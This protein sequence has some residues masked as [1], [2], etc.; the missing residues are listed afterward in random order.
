MICTVRVNFG[1]VVVVA[2]IIVTYRYC[3]SGVCACVSLRVCVSV[4]P[5]KHWQN[6]QKLRML[7]GIIVKPAVTLFRRHF[8][9]TVDPGSY[10]RSVD[11]K[12]LFVTWKLLVI[13]DAILRGIVC[14]FYKLNISIGTFG[15]NGC[16]FSPYQLISPNSVA[17]A[18]NYVK[19]IEN[20]PILSAQMCPKVS[21]FFAIFSDITEN[22]CIDER[23]SHLKAKIR[24][25]RP[26]QQ[27]LSSCLRGR[28]GDKR[29]F[30][31]VR[32]QLHRRTELSLLASATA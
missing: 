21:S 10:F 7:T 26:S 25:S 5:C 3:F 20:R 16:L 19:V 12:I 13:F 15:R 24:L 14:W 18:A 23:C 4:C 2:V 31:T 27:Q 8:T 29:G 6:D 17:L 11:N 1:F 22:E 28:P 32:W 9:F 30:A